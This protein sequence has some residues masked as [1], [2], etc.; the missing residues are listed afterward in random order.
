MHPDLAAATERIVAMRARVA[1]LPDDGVPVQEI[2]DVLCEG[3]AHAL[4]GD[5]WLTR[6]EQRLHDLIDDTSLPIRGRDLR[7]LASEHG[8]F[9]RSVIALR[10][11]LERLRR[12]HERAQAGSRARS[13]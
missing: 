8:N 11:E 6:A 13:S 10:L 9:Q 3:Y 5:A 7:V 12:E 2:E 1:S 4:A